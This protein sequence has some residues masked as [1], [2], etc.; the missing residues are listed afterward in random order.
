[1]LFVEALFGVE[2]GTQRNVFPQAQTAQPWLSATDV[3]RCY[4]NLGH[5]LGF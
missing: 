2:K 4:Q 5:P 3:P 1:M